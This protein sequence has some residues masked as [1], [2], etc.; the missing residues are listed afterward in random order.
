MQLD[1]ETNLKER[2]APRDTNLL[3]E[4]E[5]ANMMGRLNCDS[6]NEN[7]NSW[8]CN[9][10]VPINKQSKTFNCR[11]GS[12]MLRGCTLKNTEY[13]IGV[14]V[15]TGPETKIMMN[16]KKPPAKVSNVQRM[17]NYM[18]YSVFLFQ[19][20]LILIFAILSNFWFKN[21][22][23]DH[24]YLGKTLKPGIKTVFL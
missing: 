9:V 2:T 3:Q 20:I 16:A 1:G 6:P 24:F 5:V 14:V 21:N 11:E 15:N 17:M 4:L 10:T 18:L 13:C 23:S 8:D 12:L 22:G 19:L 7:M